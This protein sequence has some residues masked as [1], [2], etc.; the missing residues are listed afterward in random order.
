MVVG[1][2]M[3]KK[4]KRKMKKSAKL[5]IVFLAF[6]LGIMA[7]LFFEN[8]STNFNVKV[9]EVFDEIIKNTKKYKN[10]VTD[11]K[12]FTVNDFG[13]EL[14]NKENE[15]KK[16]FNTN[17]NFTYVDLETDYTFDKSGSSESYAASVNKFPAVFYAYHLADDGKLDLNKELKYTSN[18]THGGSGII[19][20]EKVGTK[21]TI[22]KLLEYAI[23]YSDNIAYFMILDQIGGTS[24]VK[25]YWKSL[26]VNI[27]YTDKFGN[28]STNLGASYLKEAYKY[29]L[30]GKENAKKL[31]NNM[32]VSDNLD[33]IKNEGVNYDF[34]HKYGWYESYY[35]DIS[36][37][38]SEHPYIL[39]ITST[40]GFNNNTKNYF[41][42]A[43]SLASE[44]NSEYYKEKSEYCIQKVY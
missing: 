16:Y 18:Y 26:G 6:L 21:Y 5:L 11:P 24:K 22:D 43:H 14:K 9:H 30:S 34:R 7:F 23:K 27:T 39:T 20:K 33:F 15:L 40:K 44:F 12:E 3:V 32:K 2:F 41:L 36:I 17:A 4:K 28:L 19:Q 31:Y 10:C 42:K 1:D 38:M 35:N 29:F 8:D 37:V 13:E 25:E